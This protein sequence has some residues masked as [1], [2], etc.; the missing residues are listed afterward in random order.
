MNSDAIR[1]FAEGYDML[2]EGSRVLCALSGGLDSVTLLHWLLQQP[3]LTVLCAH[4]NHCLRGE[5]SLRD[6]D[7]VRRL[8]A[9]WGVKCLVE[10]GDVAAYAGQEGLGVEEA[11][12][13]LRY[14]FLERCA[15][16]NDCL[17]IVT[18]HHAEDNAETL[19]L[20]LTRGAGLKGLCGIPPMRGNIVRPLLQTGRDEIL[21]YAR[22]HD[23]PF[24]SDSSNE[25]DD[26]ARNRIRHHVLP[27]LR[28]QN[29]A[30]AGSMARTMEL[31]RLDEAYLSGQAQAF[32][33]E[34]LDHNQTLPVSRL[35]DLPYALRSRVL[36]SMC[37]PALERQHVQAIDMLCRNR[38]LHASVDVPGLRVSKEYDR[39]SFGAEEMAELPERELR[40]GEKLALPEIG[41]VVFCEEIAA[42][43]EI[44]KSFN[45]FF[46]KRESICGR[47]IVA[48]RRPGAKVEL[49]GRNCRKSLKKLFMEAELTLAQR[50]S[51]PVFYDD[52]GVIA[53]GGFGVARRCVPEEG[54]CSIKIELVYKDGRYR[55]G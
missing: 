55:D 34:N 32:L 16:D 24:V 31:L 27:I 6:E 21:A 39:L 42:G 48:S 35:M 12:R 22:Q 20:N 37:G 23:L 18:A 28:E 53:L 54:E 49:A 29:P 8:C 14:D 44:N 47:I 46:L 38:A 11:A 26:F 4:Y 50:R 51:T 13:K 25:S 15:R 45:T 43:A 2:P 5:E 19:L 52:E 36:R 41:A 17:R 30:L 40:P 10:R 1:S 33:E 9:D 7:F 3:G